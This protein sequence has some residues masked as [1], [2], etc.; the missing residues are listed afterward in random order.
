MDVTEDCEAHYKAK[1]LKGYNVT[2]EAPGR[3]NDLTAVPV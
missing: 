3:I 1:K 2:T